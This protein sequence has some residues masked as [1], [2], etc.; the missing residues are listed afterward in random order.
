[1]EVYLF[2][3]S[4]SKSR[5]FLHAYKFLVR[6]TIS[7]KSISFAKFIG[8][9]KIVN[10]LTPYTD[11][12][13]WD[14]SLVLQIVKLWKSVEMGDCAIEIA[15]KRLSMRLIWDSWDKGQDELTL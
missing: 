5:E 14:L 6:V 1:M 4:K 12:R 10:V 8:F 2:T 11:I 13:L 3:S 9:Y 7:V 15:N